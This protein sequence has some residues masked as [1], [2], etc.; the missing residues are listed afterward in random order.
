MKS[1]MTRPEPLP[2]ASRPK[3]ALTV[4]HKIADG[5]S[6]FTQGVRQTCIPYFYSAFQGDQVL[7]GLV[8]NHQVSSQHLP[9]PDI[10]AI[11]VSPNPID[12]VSRF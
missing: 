8:E 1:T 3:L 9:A 12:H 5:A 6:P 7:P 4:R 11:S 2:Y 10:S